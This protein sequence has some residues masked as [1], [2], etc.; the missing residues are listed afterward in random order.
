MIALAR[1]GRTADAL[2]TFADAREVLVE[3]AGLEPGDDLRRLEREILDGRMPTISPIAPSPPRPAVVAV[4]ADH[5]VS[6][7]VRYVEVD[8]VHVAYCSVGDAMCDLVMMN[9]GTIPVDSV[10]TEPRLARAVEQ[11]PPSPASRGSTGVAS[12]CRTARPPIG[13]PR[14]RTGCAISWPCSTPSGPPHRWS[15][16]ARTRRRSPS[17]SRS[18][19]LTVSPAS[20]SPTPRAR[21]THGDGYEHGFDPLLAEQGATETIAATPVEGGFDLLTMIAPTSP[22]TTRSAPG[23]TPLG[24]EARPRRWRG[25]CGAATRTAISARSSTGARSRCCTS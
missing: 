25:R 10:L 12:G 2:R 7:A 8:D 17:S 14:S 6:A 20:C 13:C 22:T 4:P 15:T 23:G 19:N 24:G 21:F 16:R 5:S 3:Q 11:L 1:S 9:A 18:S